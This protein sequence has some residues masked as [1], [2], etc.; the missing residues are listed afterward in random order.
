MLNILLD[1]LL[2]FGHA[3]CPALG[4]RGAG[5]ASVAAASCGTLAYCLMAWREARTNGFLAHLPRAPELVSLLRLGLPTC[6]Q[7]FMFSTGFVVLFWIIGKVR[8]P[9]ARMPT[10]WSTSL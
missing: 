8:L 1:W 10:C 3:G 7:Q 9:P 5:I 2:I 4:V 6:I